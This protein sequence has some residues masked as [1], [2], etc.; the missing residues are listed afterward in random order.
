M[1]SQFS[2]SAV[3]PPLPAATSTLPPASRL[4]PE[5]I[6]STLDHTSAC[7]YFSEAE[8]P[9]YKTAPSFSTMAEQIS[10]SALSLITDSFYL[11]EQQQFGQLRTDL[12]LRVVQSPLSRRSKDDKLKLSVVI[13]NYCQQHEV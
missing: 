6:D 4:P 3:Q 2:Y 7:V 12:F 5:F 10:S 9:A 11:I 13:G 1:T 8:N